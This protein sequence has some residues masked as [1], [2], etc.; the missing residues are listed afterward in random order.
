MT[1]LRAWLDKTIND[2]RAM[3]E[4]APVADTLEQ[5]RDRLPP[6]DLR[7]PDLTVSQ[8]AELEPVAA[9]TIRHRCRQG[10]YPGAYRTRDGQGE[11]R[12]P[13]RAIEL[14]RRERRKQGGSSNSV[15]KALGVVPSYIQ[16][17]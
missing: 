1:S 9:A 16:S 7:Y 10:E 2:A 14:W 3:G 6:E 4:H 5:V 13:W 12:I 17:R 15:R 8:V 11:W